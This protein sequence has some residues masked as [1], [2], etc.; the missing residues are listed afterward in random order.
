MKDGLQEGRER[1]LFRADHPYGQRRPKAPQKVQQRP[2]GVGEG[3][4]AQVSEDG[5]AA[6]AQIGEPEGP[7]EI[8]GKTAAVHGG[9]RSDPGHA[10]VPGGLGH[11]S[12][13]SLAH[14]GVK[15]LG[16]DIVGG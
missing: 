12:G 7:K 10:A 13:H 1:A 11:G 15:G 2:Q 5:Q 14:P 4:K 3:E 6:P 8:V 9:P 16:D